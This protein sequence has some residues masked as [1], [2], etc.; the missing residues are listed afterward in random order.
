MF[1]PEQFGQVNLKFLG[2]ALPH[3]AQVTW[4][5]AHNETDS[6]ETIATKIRNAWSQAAVMAILTSQVR[7]DSILVKLGP[8]EFGPAIE[9][10]GDMAGG[11]SGE[12]TVPNTA[13]LVRKN[14]VQGGRTGSGRMFIPG[15]V[16]ANVTGSGAV[17]QAALGSVQTR[18]D[19]LHE[20]LADSQVPMFLLHTS[21]AHPI[22]PLG[23]TSLKA[24]G[25]VATQRRRLR[26]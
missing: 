21:E 10:P 1:I 17:D 26:P 9:I 13:L 23:V 12:P 18:L 2:A 7:V 22:G 15:W 5:F 16:E 3:G 19:D 11:A 20:A 24:Q 6:I 14:T 25:T 4:G 8:N